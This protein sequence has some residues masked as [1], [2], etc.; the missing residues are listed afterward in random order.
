[1][2]KSRTQRVFEFKP[3]E[4]CKIRWIFTLIEEPDGLIIDDLVIIAQTWD[5][6]VIKGC[7]GHPK[8]LAALLRGRAVRNLPVAELASVGCPLPSSCGQILSKCLQAL[9]AEDTCSKNR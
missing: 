8:S 6:G 5:N 2:E 4:T 3:Q 9:Q 1:M 7:H